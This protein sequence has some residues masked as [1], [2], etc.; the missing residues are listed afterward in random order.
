[1]EVLTTRTSSEQILSEVRN[2]IGIITL[3]RPAALN[4]LSLDM[5]DALQIVFDRFARDP[6]IYA[7]LL[8]GAGEKAFCAGGDVRALYDSFKGSGT[9][10]HEF[11]AIEYRLDYALH[12]Y[13]K[14]YMALLDGITMGGGMGLAQSSNLRIVG[15]RT[16]IAMPEVGIGL[17]PDVGG[18]Y[19]LSRLPGSLGLY[20][21]LTGNP[22]RA[23]DALYA[24][25]A[26]MYLSPAL[27]KDLEA[28]LDTLVWSAD[29]RAD[30]RQTLQALGA[31]RSSGIS[32]TTPEKIASPLSLESLRPA[33][34]RHFSKSTLSEIL[35]S[36]STEDRAEFCEWSAKTIKVMGNRSPT[37]MKVTLKQLQQGRHLSLA[38]CFRMELAMTRQCF[39]QG[40]FIEGVRALIVDKDNAPHWSPARI[41]DVPDTA[42]E[43]FFSNPWSLAGHP[44]ADLQHVACTQASCVQSYLEGS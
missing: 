19:F 35:D 32:T 31:T 40:D 24:G 21:A 38:D 23:A 22:I 27:I 9:L 3:N 17:F 34:D 11:F 37:M 25:L 2:H 42:V 5:I 33:I 6:H 15:D 16:R 36:L 13:P 20:L 10:H 41:E 1:M 29:P 44:L 7:V 12:H 8:R 30:V 26:D 14:P 43:A 39:L 28:T 4:A 18:S